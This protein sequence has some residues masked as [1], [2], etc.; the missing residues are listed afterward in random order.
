MRT[1]SPGPAEQQAKCSRRIC[2]CQFTC[3][4]REPSPGN[5]PA[6]SKTPSFET[7]RILLKPRSLSPPARAPGLRE[8]PVVPVPLLSAMPILFPP[9]PLP[10]ARAVFGAAPAVGQRGSVGLL[11]RRKRW[12]WHGRRRLR[13]GARHS[14]CAHSSENAHTRKR[15]HTSIGVENWVHATMRCCLHVS[16]RR[17]VLF[18]LCI[19]AVLSCARWVCDH[20]NETTQESMQQAKQ[21]NRTFN[22]VQQM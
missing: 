16:V 13:K 10:G 9:L 18:S 4:H 15:A 7:A 11:P 20:Q 12:R 8:V 5:M 19:H 22:D 14:T 3:G 6:P 2:R 17:P 1:S 21:K